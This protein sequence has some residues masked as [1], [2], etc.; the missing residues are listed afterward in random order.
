MSPHHSDQIP[1]DKAIENTKTNTNTNTKQKQVPS[2]NALC[3]VSE[4]AVSPHYA[5]SSTIV[6]D[7]CAVQLLRYNVQL[8]LSMRACK[9]LQRAS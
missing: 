6:A 1:H 2:D 9:H 4:I 3:R 8:C 5:T 7:Q